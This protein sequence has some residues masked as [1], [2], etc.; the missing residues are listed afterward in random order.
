MAAPSRSRPRARA[1]A[2]SI[3]HRQ[4][5][6]P[7]GDVVHFAGAGWEPEDMLDIVLNDE[8]QTHPPLQ[9]SVTVGSDGTFTDDTY[10]VDEGDLN[11]TFTL[12][13]TSRSNGQSLSMTFTDGNLQGG[14]AY[15]R[16]R[17]RATDRTASTSIDVTIGGNGTDCTVTLSLLPTPALPAGASASIT[18]N[19]VQTG[20]TNF[21]R[22]LTFTTTS[23]TPGSY[24]FTV[25]A[26]R[27]ANCQGNGNVDVSGNRWCSAPRPSSCMAS[28]RATRRVAVSSRLRR[29]C[30]CSM[31]TTTSSPTAARA[32]R[33]R[34]RTTLVAGPWPAP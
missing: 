27:G 19:T 5:R 3:T 28:S 34:S 11:V 10:T 31:P 7:A 2:I 32:F 24:P 29:P 4:G 8:P 13:A 12:M 21:S 16:E 22:T 14:G 25:H 23:V 30:A 15:A 20:S 1:M 6:L 18:P 9:W 17:L 26:V 33:S